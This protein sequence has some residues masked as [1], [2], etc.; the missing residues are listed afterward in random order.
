VVRLAAVKI[1]GLSGGIGTG[2]TTVA[3]FLEELGAAVIDADDVGHQV[4]ELPEVKAQ[5][6]ATFGNDILF[7]QGTVDRKRVAAIVFGNETA[8]AR[9]NHIMHPP[10]RRLVERELEEYRIKG[11]AVAVLEAPLLEEAGW[12]EMVDQLWVTTAPQDV[13]LKRLIEKVG[14]TE[15]EAL[16]RINSQPPQQSYTARADITLETDTSLDELKEKVATLWP[17]K[18]KD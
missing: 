6:T 9:L 17:V 18:K 15:E 11:T 5:L 3:G 13:V 12:T 2:K 1:I 16:A 8:L 7:S 4:L 14:L 10:I